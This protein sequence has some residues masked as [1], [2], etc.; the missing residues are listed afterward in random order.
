MDDNFDILLADSVKI[1]GMFSNN[2]QILYE[3]QKKVNLNV[4]NTIDMLVR[5]QNYLLSFQ[6]NDEYSSLLT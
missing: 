3:L 4:E 6:E 1:P 5:L 2:S